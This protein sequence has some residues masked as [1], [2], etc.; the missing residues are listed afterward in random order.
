MK[1]VPVAVRLFGSA[2]GSHASRPT[3][4]PAPSFAVQSELRE[5]EQVDVSRLELRVVSL[6]NGWVPL[7]HVAADQFAFA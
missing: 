1:I 6:S 4:V 7:V 3:D 5:A 2:V